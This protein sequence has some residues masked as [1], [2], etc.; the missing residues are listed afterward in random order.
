MHIPSY[1]LGGHWVQERHHPSHVSYNGVL[2]HS[3]T[4]GKNIYW[5]HATTKPLEASQYLKIF[6]RNQFTT[7]TTKQCIKTVWKTRVFSINNL[8]FFTFKR[9]Q[10]FSFKISWLFKNFI[11]VKKVTNWTQKHTVKLINWFIF[12]VTN[13]DIP[14]E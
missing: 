12:P 8:V 10:I 6:L 14:L 2:L 13:C 7:W 3:E 9:N 11:K 4:H 5:K 1:C